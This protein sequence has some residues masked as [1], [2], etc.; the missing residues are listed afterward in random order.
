[1]RSCDVLRAQLRAAGLPP[2][3]ID[4]SCVLDEGEA[5]D[6]P[7]QADGVRLARVAARLRCSGFAIVAIVYRAPRAPAALGF[8]TLLP[9]QLA[10]F[11]V[12]PLGALSQ[13]PSGEQL[14]AITG[15]DPIAGN[16]IEVEMDNRTARNWLLSAIAASRIRVHLQVYMAADDDVGRMVEAA[17]ANAAARG[18]PVRLLVDSLHGLYGSLGLRNPLLERLG[19]YPGIELRVSKPISSMPS[20]VELKQRD[21]RKLAVIDGEVA[22]LGGRN[23]SHEYYTGFDEVHLTAGLPWRSVPW[24]E[25]GARVKG[26]AVAALERLFLQAWTEAG[27]RPFDVPVPA[28]VGQTKARVIGHCGLQDAYSLETYLALLDGA[29]SH[30]YVVN[31]F[32]LLL[33]I[34]HALLRALSRGVRV[35]TLFGNLTP[36]YG[37]TLFK[38]PWAQARAAATSFVHSRMDPLVAAR[39][40]CYE[41]VVPHSTAWDTE[42]G[43]LR[44]HVH[45]KTMSVDGRICV[46]GSA[47]FDVTAAY[48]E[49]ELVLVIEDAA[50]ATALEGRFDELLRVSRRVDAQDPAWRREAEERRWMRYWPG[51][52]SI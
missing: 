6:V 29:C 7:E 9:T 23:L 46:L 48:W 8:A 14:S 51:N 31:G 41:F 1:M 5:T 35:R 37:D 49:N 50:I 36:R 44:P 16:S 10:T 38:G 26:P 21:H 2:L 25:A 17:L 12:K 13:L 18:V 40:E 22:L 34:Q 4:A 43:D 19:A 39:A 47:N 3:I 42:V 24:L 32:P 28:P 11:S 52:L 45:A 20:L 30:I 33:E 15:T 27:G